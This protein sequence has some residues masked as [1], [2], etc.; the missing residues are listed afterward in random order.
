[1]NF[2]SL[3]LTISCVVFSLF[4][5]TLV[6]VGTAQHAQAQTSCPDRSVRSNQTARYAYHYMERRIGSTASCTADVAIPTDGIRVYSSWANCRSGQFIFVR[7][8]GGGAVPTSLDCPDC[9]ANNGRYVVLLPGTSSSVTAMFRFPDGAMARYTATIARSD[10]D[11]TT[12]AYICSIRDAQVAGGAF[13]GDIDP[14]TVSLGALTA[15]G[16]GTYTSVITLSEAAGSATAFELD[17]LTLTNATATLS[18]SGTS[19]T[20]TLTPQADGIIA[21]GVPAAVFKDAAGNPNLSATAVS[22]THDSTAPTVTLSGLPGAFV[23]ASHLVVSIVFSETV[24]GFDASDATVGNASVTA[25]SG[26]GA[27]YSITLLANGLGDVTIQIPAGVAQDAAGNPNLGSNALSATNLTV[28]QTQQQIATYMTSRANNLASHQPDLA[29]FLSQVCKGRGLD[30]QATDGQ[31]NF[32]LTSSP[33]GPIWFTLTGARNTFD[34]AQEDYV[35]ATFG[36]H[37][38]LSENALLGA[39]IE[40]DYQSTTS[41]NSSIEGNGW[42]VGPYFVG[43]LPDQPVFFEGRALFGASR[44]KITPFGT[45]TDRFETKRGLVQAKVSGELRFQPMTVRPF[46]SASFTF[47]R[48]GSYQD[49]LGNVIPEQ[50]VDMH[51]VFAGFD[52]QRPLIINSQDWSLT[53]GLSLIHSDSRVTG[54]QTQTQSA[55]DGTR[56]R[57]ELGLSR[58]FEGGE[59][60]V[61]GFHDGIGS[62]DFR[63]VGVDIAFTMNF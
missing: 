35:L 40:L 21:V 9:A 25:F 60:S 3:L 34:H 58:A 16:N 61:S 53:G 12:G 49:S 17:D 1:M 33:N 48:M 27:A 45:Y 47:D 55:V 37:I 56:G 52:F 50:A 2:K 13:G 62:S 39:M 4:V 36:S 14:P 59:I 28:E 26:S 19:F 29:C 43:K 23:D 11:P 46:V 6:L 63:S 31:L 7:E 41:A 10:A 57:F 22:T 32:G 44:N 18:G 20:A 54:A 15:V 8:S 38:A 42:L 30:V 51:Q 5:S 24:I